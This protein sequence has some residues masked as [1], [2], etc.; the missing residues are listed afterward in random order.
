[1]RFAVP[2][3]NI[4]VTANCMTVTAVERKL[5]EKFLYRRTVKGLTVDGYWLRAEFRDLLNK[6]YGEGGW[7]FQL[8]NGWAG[9]LFVDSTFHVN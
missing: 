3:E 2:T 7:D 8:S 5:Y 1:M 6:E 4:L 9:V